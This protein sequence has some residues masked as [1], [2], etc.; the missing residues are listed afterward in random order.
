[1][2]RNSGMCPDWELNWWQFGLQ[3]G[4]QSTEPQQPGQIVTI[5]IGTCVR[6]VTD[7]KNRRS[8]KGH[9][10]LLSLP[11]VKATY[12]PSNIRF[13]SVLFLNISRN[14]DSNPSNLK[15]DL[16]YRKQVRVE[17]FI[18]LSNSSILLNLKPF[19]LG[20][21]FHS[22]KRLVSS[23]WKILNISHDY[24]QVTPKLSPF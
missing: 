3:S 10:F 15:Q 6:H 14:C 20:L 13:L 1:M 17:N 16:Y 9:F 24:P 12:K 11:L 18:L 22:R 7:S 19:I 2:A 4:T 5:L 23:Y 21:S 8:S